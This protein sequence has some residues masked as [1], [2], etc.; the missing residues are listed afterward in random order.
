MVRY[1]EWTRTAP[2]RDFIDSL[3]PL[4][5]IG[6]RQLPGMR[7]VDSRP[8]KHCSRF[9]IVQTIHFNKESMETSHLVDLQKH[10]GKRSKRWCMLQRKCE[11]PSSTLAEGLDPMQLYEE[12]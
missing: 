8:A 6:E 4:A 12:D 3:R 9:T 5:I 10:Q 1:R 2:V 7:R 11:G